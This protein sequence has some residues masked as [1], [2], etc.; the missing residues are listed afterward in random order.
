MS[1]EKVVRPFQT[2][3]VF[4]PRVL[5]PTQPGQV[6]TQTEP[7]TMT[8]SGENSG[9]YDQGPDPWLYGYNANWVEDKSRRETETVRV[10]N[11]D[12]PDQYVEIER[13]NKA[14][15]KR[16][17]TGEEMQIGIE[18]DKGRGG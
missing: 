17:A 7:S 5:P 13:I 15:F 1:L 6:V 2:G 12:D 14:V 11:P 18:W 8:W 4:A 9:D 16:R 3:D 10:E